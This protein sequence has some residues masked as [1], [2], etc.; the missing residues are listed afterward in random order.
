MQKYLSLTG[1]IWGS[2][3]FEINKAL[4]DKLPSDVKEVIQRKA[5]KYAMYERKLIQQSDAELVAELKKKGM[6]V[7]EVDTRP[8]KAAIRPVYD[9]Y[10]PIYGKEIIDAINKYSK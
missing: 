4:W 7:N 5:T 3:N 10:Q 8:F 6:Q 1:H 9:K 2:A